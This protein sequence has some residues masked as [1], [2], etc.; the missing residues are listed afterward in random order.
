[1]CILHHSVYVNMLYNH[2]TRHFKN[3]LFNGC[4]VFDWQYYRGCGIPYGR[5]FHTGYGIFS[6]WFNEIWL[7]VHWVT[8]KTC[9]IPYE[10][11]A[12][13]NSA[14]RIINK[15][16][17]SQPELSF[18]E[19]CDEPFCRS[20]VTISI[21]LVTRMVCDKLLAANGTRKKLSTFHD[22]IMWRW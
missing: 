15:P 5:H 14:T 21:Q 2:M 13:R 1:M 17:C 7:V 20:D 8:M 6:L 10:N 19:V 16:A 18:V 22:P 11:P 12:V 9:R 3:N 4:E